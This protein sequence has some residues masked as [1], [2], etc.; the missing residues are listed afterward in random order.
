MEHS[1]HL[2]VCNDDVDLSVRH[3]SNKKLLYID[4]HLKEK[5]PP[6]TISSLV[7]EEIQTTDC[8][9]TICI[10]HLTNPLKKL[11]LQWCGSAVDHLIADF[12]LRKDVHFFYTIH[13]IKSGFV[14]NKNYQMISLPQRR[15]MNL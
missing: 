11:L 15:H 5:D 8:D 3:L 6:I 4:Q 13:G 2:P 1:F 7:L 12:Y 9:I 10:H 14:T